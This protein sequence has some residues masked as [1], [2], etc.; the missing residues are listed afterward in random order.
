MKDVLFYRFPGE[1]EH[2]LIGKFKEIDYEVDFPEGFVISSFDKKNMYVFEEKSILT[3]QNL[4]FHSSLRLPITISKEE[5]LAQANSFI[6]A[7]KTDKIDKAILS[8]VKESKIKPSEIVDYFERLCKKYPNTFVY[9]ASSD[10]FGTWMGATPEILLKVNN[11]SATTMSLAGTKKD[12]KQEWGSK[13]FEEQR[14]VTDS[15]FNSIEKFAISNIEKNGPYTYNAGPIYHLRT[16][17]KF[18]I[19][20]QNILP[21]IKAIHPT[22][23]VGG[24]PFDKAIELINHT[25]KHDR[26]FYSGFIGLISK[27]SSNLFVNLRCCQLIGSSAFLYLGG[28]FTKD[29]DPF[30]EWEETENKSL[31]LNSIFM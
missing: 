19:K 20:Y 2:R 28:G 22:P 24:L 4:S 31:T 7:I 18:E 3:T 27:E 14:I 5:Y 8:R 11:Q 10:K 16:D 29:S 23:A 1:Q 26:K 17:F 12:V 6:A 21:F 30:L 13:E 15:L 25:E 9:V